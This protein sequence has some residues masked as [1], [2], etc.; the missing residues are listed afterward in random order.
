MTANLD[1]IF[2]LQ[3]SRDKNVNKLPRKVTNQGTHTFFSYLSCARREIFEH[4][5]EVLTCE[6]KTMCREMKR[7]GVTEVTM[8]STATYWIPIWR[9]LEPHFRLKLVNPYF[10]KQLPGRKSDVKGRGKA[11]SISS[12]EQFVLYL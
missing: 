4:V 12:A 9:V 1:K 8:E 7:R 5:Y 11:C 10:I 3:A 6:L 2:E